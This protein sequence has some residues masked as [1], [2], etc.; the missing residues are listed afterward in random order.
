[1]RVTAILAWL[2]AAAMVTVLVFAFIEGD[3]VSEGRQLLGMPWGTVSLIDLYVGF[4]LFSAWIRFREGRTWKTLVWIAAVMLL[5]S[6]AISIYVLVGLH[7]SNGDW[8]R[9]FYGRSERISS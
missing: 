4:F 9:F 5:G 7:T 6:L 1:M 3:F 8:Q 2:G